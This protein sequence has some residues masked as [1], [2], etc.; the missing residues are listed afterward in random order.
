MAEPVSPGVFRTPA[1][2][3]TIEALPPALRYRLADVLGLV[4]ASGTAFEGVARA[5][6]EKLVADG[7]SWLGAEPRL[8]EL[9]YWMIEAG[10]ANEL[11]REGCR[12]LAQFPTGDTVKR[13]ARIALDPGTPP[14]VREEA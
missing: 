6:F 10:H 13:L 14:P 8:A 5:R 2:A 12:W 3:R 9:G 7:E 11:R 1:W 4:P